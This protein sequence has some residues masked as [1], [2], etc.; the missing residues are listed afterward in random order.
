MFFSTRVMTCHHM[1]TQSFT[2]TLICHNVPLSKRKKGTKIWLR[3]ALG[4]LLVNVVPTPLHQILELLPLLL[5]SLRKPVRSEKKKCRGVF[6]GDRCKRCSTG[7]AKLREIYIKISPCSCFCVILLS[8]NG[9]L[10]V[11]VVQSGYPYM[12]Q[13]LS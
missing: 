12:Q 6:Q 3:Y 10:V 7:P 9:K 8:T 5:A 11:W 4:P 13:S 1:V 2:M